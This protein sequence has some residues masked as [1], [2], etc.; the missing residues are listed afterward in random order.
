MGSGFYNSTVPGQLC[1]TAELY[2]PKAKSLLNCRKPFFRA[3]LAISF[4]LCL[5]TVLLP[6]FLHSM[7]GFETDNR[8]LEITRGLLEITIEITG[9]Y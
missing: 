3:K 8:L 9:D 4:I 1:S 6:Q 7:L 5:E 2:H